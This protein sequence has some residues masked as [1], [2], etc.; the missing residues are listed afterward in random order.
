M[1][2]KTMSGVEV[3]DMKDDD[4]FEYVGLA[5]LDD[6]GHEVLDPAPMYPALKFQN[7][8]SL[9]EQIKMILQETKIREAIEAE[10]Y[11]TLE[12]ADDFEVGDDFEPF[13]FH[14]FS[15]EEEAAARQF[16]AARREEEA[17]RATPAPTPPAPP[18]TAQESEPVEPPGDL[19]P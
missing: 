10:G 15:E 4:E 2:K 6:N 16:I 3:Q 17:R 14:E 11:E 13:S 8:P 12:E 19:E 5:Q 7:P 1:A 18:P 9:E